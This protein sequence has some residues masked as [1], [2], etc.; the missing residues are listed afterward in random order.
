M[1]VDRVCS[2]PSY[3][4]LAEHLKTEIARGHAAPGARLP[5]EQQLMERTALSRITVRH[6]LA[7]LEREGWIV[8][9]QGLGTF[10]G[11]AI[12]QELSRVRTIP[13][14][15]LSQGLSPEIEVRGFGVVTA[16][17]SAQLELRLRPRERVVR[18][19]RIYR[20]GGQPIALLHVYMPLSFRR[21]AAALR[22]E[23]LPT[24][25]TFSIMERQLGVRLREAR[26]VIRAGVASAEVGR[27]L[28]LR[29]GAPILILERVT[30]AED[31]RP[32]EYDL[33]H[34]HSERYKF[35]I[36]L[37]RR[38]ALRNGRGPRRPGAG[39]LLGRQPR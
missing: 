3:L 30:F 23:R 6:A 22:D 17:A 4:Q 9:R 36:T 11:H 18:I 10:A 35:S 12:D 14:V 1:T 39:G 21:H 37:P 7:L 19:K 13:E 15:F 27:A 16:P 28:R 2:I 34:Y 29:R 5:S 33:F 20:H 25:T 8:R 32:V 26:H 31:G 24:E 38:S